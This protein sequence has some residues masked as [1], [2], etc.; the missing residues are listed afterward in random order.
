[1]LISHSLAERCCPS[2]VKAF[3]YVWHPAAIDTFDS[4]FLPTSTFS[5]T[6][7]DNEW[8]TSITIA[9]FDFQVPD[10]LHE[11]VSSRYKEDRES[12]QFPPSN[13]QTLFEKTVRVDAKKNVKLH[14]TKDIKFMIDKIVKNRSTTVQIIEEKSA[15]LVITGDSQGELWV[16]TLWTSLIKADDLSVY[17]RELAQFVNYFKHQKSTARNLGFL[18]LLGI[19]CEKLANRFEEVMRSLEGYV[20][21]G[22]SA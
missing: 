9:Y 16:C 4:Y 8:I 14:K 1:M 5:N 10:N 6:R 3:I 20:E 18:F 7:E 2:L 19:L 13:V 11:S 22:V 17:L 15:A 12:G 21:L